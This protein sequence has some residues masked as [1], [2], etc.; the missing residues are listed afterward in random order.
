[1]MHDEHGYLL[2]AMFFISCVHPGIQ[3]SIDW[4]LLRAK[5][6][7]GSAKHCEPSTQPGI[8]STK[9]G[10]LTLKDLCITEWQ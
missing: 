10:S 5:G 1:M 9:S 2:K 8:C 3:H 7:W 4:H 6:T